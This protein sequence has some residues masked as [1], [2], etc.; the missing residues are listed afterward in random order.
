MRIKKS[1]NFRFG[2]LVLTFF[3]SRLA[4]PAVVPTPIMMIPTTVVVMVPMPIPAPAIIRT[5][6][7]VNRGRS[8]DYG[9]FGIIDGWRGTSRRNRCVN[10]RRRLA[11]NYPWQRRQR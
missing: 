7:E 10:R 5:E 4:M 1:R 9:R 11:D 6:A 8:Y 3:G 2:S